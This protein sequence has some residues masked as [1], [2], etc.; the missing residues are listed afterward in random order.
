[1]ARRKIKYIN[2]REL[3]SIYCEGDREKQY[4]LNYR[5]L[6]PQKNFVLNVYDP[7]ANDPL[8]LVRFAERHQQNVKADYVWCVFDHDNISDELILKAVTIA[9]QNNI[10]IAFSNV[11]FEIWMLIHFS[12]TTRCFHNKIEIEKEL[13]KH[14]QNYQSNSHYF[15]LLR[16]KLPKAIQHANE[17]LDSV[18]QDHYNHKGNPSTSVVKLVSDLENKTRS[19]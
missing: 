2:P 19:I 5:V 4:F 10:N 9:Q 8:S 14:I 13:K 1:M 3:I 11:C 7:S 6:L 17:L 12:D 16:D 15:D 18:G